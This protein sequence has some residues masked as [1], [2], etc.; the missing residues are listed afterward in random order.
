MTKLKIAN[1]LPKRQKCGIATYAKNLYAQSDK[2]NL[3]SKTTNSHQD[4]KIEVQLSPFDTKFSDLFNLAFKKVDVIHFQHEFGIWPWFGLSF[5]IYLVIYK[6]NFGLLDILSK[7]KIVVTMHTVWD[8]TKVDNIFAHY[9]KYLQIFISIYLGLSYSLITNLCHK[10]IVLNPESVDILQPFSTKQNKVEYLPHGLFLPENKV[11]NFNILNKTYGLKNTDKLIVMFGFAYSNKGF[12][13]VLEALPNILKKVPEAKVVLACSEPSDGGQNY[14]E[15]LQK[16][17]VKLNIQDKV[18]FTGF[19]EDEDEKLKAIF[20]YA[21]CFVYPYF[22][23][24]GAS[25]SVATV[26]GYEKPILVSDINFFRDYNFLPKFK[27]GSVSNLT[28]QLV[29]LL[30]T[31]RDSQASKLYLKNIENY[32]DKYSIFRSFQS[33]I[34]IFTN[35]FTTP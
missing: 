15:N 6:I 3:E 10:I 7:R 24:S 4:N 13:L 1:H 23:R 34:K 11:A 33:Q 31:N 16:L 28:L 5:L 2:L 27:E 25:G 17:V 26:F 8:I 22:E 19:L 30:L 9:P 12:H 20:N 32:L 18:I 14:M 35:L 29:E 21:H